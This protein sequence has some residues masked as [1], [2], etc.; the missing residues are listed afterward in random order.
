MKSITHMYY[1]LV[2]EQSDIENSKYVLQKTFPCGIVRYFSDSYPFKCSLVPCTTS[3]KQ[4]TA[5]LSLVMEVT[6]H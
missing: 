6:D 2:E 5:L 1:V 4:Y 3:T